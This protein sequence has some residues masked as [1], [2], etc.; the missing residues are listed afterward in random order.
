MN[1]AGVTSFVTRALAR[2]GERLT[3]GR[4]GARGAG[5]VR[6]ARVKTAVAPGV[7]K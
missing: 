6:E 2:L 5:A 3:R 1:L 7:L 4:G